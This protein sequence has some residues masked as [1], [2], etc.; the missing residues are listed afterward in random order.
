MRK[1]ASAVNRVR[2]DGMSAQRSSLPLLFTVTLGGR[3]SFAR[4][5]DDPAPARPGLQRLQAV[6]NQALGF[7][8]LGLFLGLGLGSRRLG[9]RR[10][11]DRLLLGG[12]GRGRRWR[13]WR[14]HVFDDLFVN[15]RR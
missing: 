7:E 11:N 14:R 3:G 13:R 8:G 9:L 15:N 5:D 2:A 12:R 1:A 4:A 10:R 6:E